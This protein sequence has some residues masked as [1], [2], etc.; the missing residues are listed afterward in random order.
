MTDN[1]QKLI[2]TIRTLSIDAVQA[3]NSGHPGAPMGLAPAAYTLYRNTM[4]FNPQDPKWFNRDRFVLSA[5]HAS[6]LLYSSLFL[7]GFEI[8]LDDIKNFR[9]YKSK[10]AGHPEFGMTPGVETTTGP[11]GQ[12]AATSVGIAI[13]E[14]WLKN[15]YNKENFNIID[16]KTYVILGDGCMME[17]ITS[18]TASIAGHLKLDNLVWI[19]DSNRISIE[20]STDITFTEDVE[21]RFKAYGWN[22]TKVEDINN[23]EAL[24]SALVDAKNYSGAPSLLIVSSHIAYGSP[25]KQDSE[26]SHGAPLGNDEVKAT[27]KFYNVD[28]DATF[29]LP[30]EVS[31]MQEE[32]RAKGKKSQD[33]WIN[34]FNNYKKQYAIEAAEIEMIIKGE[35]PAGVVGEMEFVT[36]TSKKIA[37]RTAGGKVINETAKRLPWLVGGSADL[38]PSNKSVITSSKFIAAGDFSGSNIH[39]GVREHAMGAIANGLTISGL[40]S[41]C[42]TFFV[43]SDYMRSSIRL[44]ALMNIPT[45][46]IFTHDSIGVGEDG[47]THQPVEHLAGLRSIPNLNVFRPAD[48]NE[49]IALWQVALESSRPTALIL[50]R[51]DLE[52]LD[53]ARLN[54]ASN[55]TKGGYILKDSKETPELLMI[56]TGSEVEIAT[57][58]A[59]I[60]EKEGKKIRLISMP[61][62]EL[63]E[64]MDNSYKEEILPSS[65]KARLVIEAASPFGW[66]RYAWDDE[67]II[68]VR[69]FGESAPPAK[70]YDHFGITPENIAEKARIII[71]KHS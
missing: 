53:Q 19:Y 67:A 17:G 71:K 62:L 6:M 55:A 4:K 10:C 38:G 20:G 56:A 70:V 40:K 39:Y 34:L 26:E 3:A 7:A 61:S 24:N 28:P 63:F 22:V 29:S 14:K 66:H 21:A 65:I 37:T 15:R 13:A 68:G 16:Y 69:H 45:I 1:D 5:G 36:D 23:L 31:L 33:A 11:L 18:E 44:A 27:K 12:G 2:N 8:S 43:F 49:T 64:E 9:Q 52:V 59:E 35:L 47:P 51:Q 46:F 54:S 25:N 60:L 42:A 32:L 58:A 50:S 57:K 30:K 41:F 48:V